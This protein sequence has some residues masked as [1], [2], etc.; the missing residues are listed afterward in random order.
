MLY[1]QNTQ[2]THT[3]Q[4]QKKKKTTE[5][6]PGFSKTLIFHLNGQLKFLSFKG[7]FAIISPNLFMIFFCQLEIDI[8]R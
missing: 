8:L 7:V 2:R 5:K 6:W 4:Q 1:L 3:T